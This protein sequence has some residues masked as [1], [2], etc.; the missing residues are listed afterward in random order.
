MTPSSD[1]EL[2]QEQ[3]CPPTVHSGGTVGPLARTLSSRSE[4][5]QLV[6]GTEDRVKADV[7]SLN[8]SVSSS[9]GKGWRRRRGVHRKRRA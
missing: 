6:A 7:R 2:L 4:L 3:K 9:E 1:E 8:P 5:Y